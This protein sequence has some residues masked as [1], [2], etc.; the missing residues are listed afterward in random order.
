V[1]LT[2]AEKII[3]LKTLR[4]EKIIQLN[5]LGVHFKSSVL[6]VRTGESVLG[7]LVFFGVE[8]RSG[9]GLGSLPS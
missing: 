4:A 9:V 7:E 3:Q 2:V 6:K 1:K 5:T 8:S